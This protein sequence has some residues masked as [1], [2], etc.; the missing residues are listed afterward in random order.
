MSQPPSERHRLD[1][2]RDDGDVVRVDARVRWFDAVRGVGEV[3]VPGIGHV[4][5][6]YKEVRRGGYR[7]LDAGD[8]VSCWIEQTPQGPVARDVIVRGSLPR[9]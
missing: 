9:E 3:R 6:Y 2:V 8:V 4:H 5:V 1:P 7:A